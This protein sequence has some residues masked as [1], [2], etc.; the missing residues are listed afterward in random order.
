MKLK[1]LVFSY[2]NDQCHYGPSF[3]TLGELT[4]SSKEEYCETHGY[5]FYLKDNNFDYSRRNGFERWDIFLEKINDYDWLWYLEADSMIMNHTIR[6]ENL[7]DDRYDI[8]IAKT[9]G[10]TAEKKEIN[11]GSILIKKSNWS[12]SFLKY[13]DSLTQYYYHPWGTQQAIID[14]INFTHPEEAEKHIKIVPLRY[15]NSYYHK[16]HPDDNFQ[17]GDFVLHA[18]GSSNDYRIA[19][20]NEVQNYIIRA[21]KINIKIPPFLNLG[22]EKKQN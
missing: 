12:I 10:S 8:I 2:H 9:S 11:N 21:P 7:I 13:I 6:L 17:N 14:Y 1:F 5:D 16:W 22:D 4:R 20:F 15:F 18:A 3:K 19:L